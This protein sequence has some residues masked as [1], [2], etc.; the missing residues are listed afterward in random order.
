MAEFRPSRGYLVPYERHLPMQ[1]VRVSVQRTFSNR[2]DESSDDVIVDL[3]RFYAMATCVPR[4][5]G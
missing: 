4:E 1:F 5:A 3:A 2:N